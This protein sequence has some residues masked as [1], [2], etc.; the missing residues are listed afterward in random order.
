[1]T[2]P[3]CALDHLVVLCASLAD[4]EA[5]CQATLGLAPG[6]GGRH[7]LMGTHNRLLLLAGEG[8][9]PAYLELIAI[10]PDA[11]VPGRARCAPA[12]STGCARACWRWG[13][14]RARPWPCRARAQPACCNGGCWCATTA[15]SPWMATCR[16]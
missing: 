14:T 6:P 3:P 12:R 15:P 13:M 8:M 2:A 5:W 11:P 16:P 1:M 7:A 10:D 4:G 9:A